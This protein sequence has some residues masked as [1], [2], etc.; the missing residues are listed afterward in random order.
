MNDPRCWR[1]LLLRAGTISIFAAICYF[2][3]GADAW[4]W[5]IPLAVAALVLLK[6]AVRPKDLDEDED[7][8]CS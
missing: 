3:L 2:R 1:E 5:Y 8:D 7:T 6:W 4:V